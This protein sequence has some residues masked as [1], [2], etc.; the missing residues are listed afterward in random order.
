MLETYL[1]YMILGCIAYVVYDLKKAKSD[2]W[3]VKREPDN[4]IERIGGR[5]VLKEK[6]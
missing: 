5:F 6:Q 2:N 1:I 4:V 3:Y